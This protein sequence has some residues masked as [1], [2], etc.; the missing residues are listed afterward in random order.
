FV[1]F[2][3]HVGLPAKLHILR[4]TQRYFERACHFVQRFHFGP[5]DMPVVTAFDIVGAGLDRRFENLFL[6]AGGRRV[7]DHALALE[8]VG[9]RAF[10][11]KIAAILG[12]CGAYVGGGAVAIVGQRFDDQG[13]AAGAIALIAHFLVILA[14][15]SSGLV[16]RALDI[17][18]RHRLGLGVVDRQAQA[19][20][21]VWIGRAHLGGHGYLAAELG[22]QVGTLF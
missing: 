22:K 15:G 21:H 9:D 16:D 20:V 4:L 17:V 3:G 2:D 13:D 18:L 11:S 6:V 8:P 12:E 5:D 14:A 7:F 19:R 10:G 1:H